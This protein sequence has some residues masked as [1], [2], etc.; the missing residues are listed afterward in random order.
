MDVQPEPALPVPGRAHFETGDRGWLPLDSP[1]GSALIPVLGGHDFIAGVRLDGL[2]ERGSKPALVAIEWFDG[3]GRSLSSRGP[4]SSSPRFGEHRYLTRS[5]DRPNRVLLTAP[6]GAT[7]VRLTVHPWERSDEPVLVSNELALE[8]RGSSVKNPRAKRLEDLVIAVVCD[9]FTYNSL[10][11]EARLVVLEPGTWRD[12]LES[13]PP[14]LFFCESAWSGVDS[15]VRPWKGQVYAS[16]NF[17]KENRNELLGILD[18]CREREIPTVFWNKED[19]AHYEDRVHDFVATA[20]LFEH[21][22]TTA[23]ECVDRYRTEHGHPSV[24]T[25]PFATQPR[26][27]NPIESVDRSEDVIFA[28]S[29][30]AQH[31]DRCVAMTEILDGIMDAGQRI[32]I[33]DRQSERDDPNHQWP[34]RYRPYVLPG[35]SHVEVAG[36]YK[37]SQTALNIN[38][39]TQSRTMFARRVFELMSSNTLVLSNYS[40]GMD[41]MFG[42]LV[43]FMDRDPDRLTELTETEHAGLRAR[44]LDLV[45]RRHTYKQRLQ[46]V[47]GVAGIPLDQADP[48]VG[49]AILIHGV[50]QGRQIVRTINESGPLVQAVLLVVSPSVEPLEVQRCYRELASSTVEVLDPRLCPRGTSLNALSEVQEVLL[51]SGIDRLDIETL[52]S[53][54]LHRQY[55]SDPIALVD[56]PQQIHRYMDEAVID[57]VLVTRRDLPLYLDHIGERTRGVFYAV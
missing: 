35:V 51:L 23:E 31:P 2:V 15:H 1:T 18:H 28:G 52:E 39:V 38:T 40:L 34:D 57:S 26:H 42:D 5:G 56:E 36:L 44:A 11:P 49:V 33:Y 9:E 12:Q 20:L 13:T 32:R 10:A 16:R 21:I 55:V 50:E 24:H 14:D 37:A 43:V 4:I 48:A 8:F 25:L 29:W 45:L 27:F 7:T 54:L 47:A 6:F 17:A 3:G 46:F 19:P 30:Y 41:E 53:A 22:F